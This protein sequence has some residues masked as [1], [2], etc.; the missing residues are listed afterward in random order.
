VG[1]WHSDNPLRAE[2]TV[3]KLESI[4]VSEGGSVDL[5]DTLDAPAFEL[6]A[7]TIIGRPTVRAEELSGGSSLHFQ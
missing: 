2:A 1:G 3:P 4:A 6:D 5:I 7:I